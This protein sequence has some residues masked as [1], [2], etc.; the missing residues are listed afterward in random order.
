MHNDWLITT[1][2]PKISIGRPNKLK[3]KF[4]NHVVFGKL[5]FYVSVRYF[6]VST[7]YH[8]LQRLGTY[9]CKCDLCNIKCIRVRERLDVSQSTFTRFTVAKQAI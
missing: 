8:G 4:R 1:E 5:Q 9:C 2:R 7:F 6:M 3:A